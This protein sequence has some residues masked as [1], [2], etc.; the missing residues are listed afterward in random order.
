MKNSKKIFIVTFLI[1]LIILNGIVL[2][3][4][5][6]SENTKSGTSKKSNSQLSFPSTIEQPGKAVYK[7]YCMTC[8]QSNGTGV[9]GMFPPIGPGSWAGKSPDDLI[10]LILKGLN[11]EIDVNGERYKSTMPPQLTISDKELADVLSYVRSNFGNNFK[12][13]TIDMVKKVRAT[14]LPVSK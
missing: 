13:V 12:P 4:N 5:I 2:S 11:G 6:S 9:P 8:H 14:L 7:K 1:F 3:Q 10:A